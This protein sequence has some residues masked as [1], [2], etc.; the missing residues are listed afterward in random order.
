MI[1][2]GFADRERDGFMPLRKEAAGMAEGMTVSDIAKKHKVPVSDIEEQLKAGIKVEKEHTD[3]EAQAKQIAM[4]HI[5]EIKD[6]Y[7]RL[8]EME[9][10]AEEEEKEEEEGGGKTPTTTA[11]SNFLSG[12]G[13]V[14]DDMFHDWAESNGYDVHKAE[15][16]AYRLAGMKK[17][18][19]LGKALLG[20][21]AVGALGAGTLAATN[22]EAAG[23]LAGKAVRGAKDLK[24][25]A[26]SNLRGA[27]V[28]M[29]R[30]FSSGE[31]RTKEGSEMKPGDFA[32]FAAEVR[33]QEA[34][35]DE[36]EKAAGKISAGL[37][38]GL[39][40][41][42]GAA[43]GAGRGRRLM[44]AGGSHVG[45]I[46]GGGAGAGRGALAGIPGGPA[47]MGVGAYLGALSGMGAGG[48]VGAVKG[49]GKAEKLL[50]A[51]SK[52]DKAKAVTK[53]VIKNM[54]DQAG[55]IVIQKP[56]AT[57]AVGGLVSG[58]ALSKAVKGE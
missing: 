25:A 56:V 48:A 13:K 21:G 54:A 36:M 6:Y 9:A 22:P 45:Q 28:K 27:Q 44:A 42:S 26:T 14:T 37:L 50:A 2:R 4:D 15:E 41:P 11:V 16:V 53:R 51:A 24:N 18:A 23:E 33:G 30:G 5:V 55:E 12:S 17:E 46:V 19:R 1:P 58:V 3:D 47:G 57:A 49:V 40:G 52:A 8:K 34:T 38:G 35:G 7:D 39:F 10:E 43:I 29:K 20:L 32:K 31:M